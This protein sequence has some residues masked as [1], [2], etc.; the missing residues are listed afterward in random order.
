MTAY[1]ELPKE[2]RALR[3]NVSTSKLLIRTVKKAT[4][5]YTKDMSNTTVVPG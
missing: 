1:V 5:M 4:I 2:M 3:D